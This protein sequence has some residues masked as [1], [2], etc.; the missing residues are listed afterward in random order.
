MGGMCVVNAAQAFAYIG[1]F[2][3]SVRAAS[4]DCPVKKNKAACSAS[5]NDVLQSF[6][7]V[8]SY[9]SNAAALCGK[10]VMA[11]PACIGHVTSV[12]A[13]FAEIAAGASGAS[14]ACI[15]HPTIGF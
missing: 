7:L 14:A 3:E 6:F 10:T 15:P 1:H 9:L 11:L 2:V 12:A 13:G 4:K 8:F 5:V